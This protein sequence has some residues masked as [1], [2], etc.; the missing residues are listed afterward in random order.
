MASSDISSRFNLAVV[1]NKVGRKLGFDALRTEQEEAV[2]A[3]ASG[4]DV[5]INLHT[6]LCVTSF[7]L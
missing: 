1:A 4:K 6:G 2:C 5:F 3:F 7:F